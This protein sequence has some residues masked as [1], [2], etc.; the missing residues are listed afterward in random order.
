MPQPVADEPTTPTIADEMSN[1]RPS[2]ML[3]AKPSPTIRITDRDE[4][5]AIVNATIA[6]G[7]S[8]ADQLSLFGV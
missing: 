7:D 4:L 2:V 8:H 3:S 5:A 6:L 1:P